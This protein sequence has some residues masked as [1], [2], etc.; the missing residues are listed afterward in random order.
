MGLTRPRLGQFQTTTAAFDDEIIVLNNS[1]SGANA[2]DIGIVFERGDSAN[3]ALIWDESADT[4]ALISTTEQGGT[5]GNVGI[6][7]YSALKVGSFI[8]SGIT[9]PTS[10]GSSGQMV[11]TDGSG[12]LSFSTP[13]TVDTSKMPLAGG[14]FTGAVT[15]NSTFDG[16]DVATDGAKLDGIE[17]SATADQT[18]AEIR[19]AVEAASDSNVF[20][21]ADHSKLNAI[22]ASADVT[23]ATNVA[24]AGAVMESDSTTASMSFVIDE[25]NLA[26]NSATKVP[27]QQSVKAYV[28]NELAGVSSDSISEGDSKIEVVD[29]GTGTAVVT[30]D[31]ATHTTFNS[32]GI[33]LATGVFSGTATSARY[34]DLAERYVSDAAYE[35]GTVL[36]FGGTK[37]VTISNTK[38]DKRIAGVVSTNP[39]Y[40]MNSD[41]EGEHVVAIA[42]QGRVPCRVIGKVEKGDII[43]SS[44]V[45]GVGV[46][47]DES[48]NPIAGSVIGKAIEN[49]FTEAE[50]T[51]EVVVGVR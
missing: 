51:I 45:E 41:C 10:D 30:L 40:L 7:S 16:R 1:A 31:N 34:A 32:S 29:A 25:D 8:A 2:N 18:D 3:T 27:T 49:K 33:T 26:S 28:D 12:N 36:V 14:A 17:A 38:E 46:V 48:R 23:D 43:V 50:K 11:V 4:F 6:T 24:A 9:Y 47:W 37:E 39:A 22:E 20:T 42:L 35:A 13:G 44:Y 5:Q 15:T 21:D 19:A